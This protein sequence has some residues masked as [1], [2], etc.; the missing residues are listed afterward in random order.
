[1]AE[2]S[3]EHVSQRDNVHDRDTDKVKETGRRSDRP[4][5]LHLQ[6]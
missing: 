2:T 6:S 1:M 4:R 5:V 3:L